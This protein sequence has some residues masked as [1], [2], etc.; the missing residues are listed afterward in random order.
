MY[1]VPYISWVLKHAIEHKTKCLYFISRDGYQLK[2]IA[3][4]IIEKKNLPIRTKYIYGS[5]R[6]WRI[7]SLITEL[8]KEFFSKFG[9]FVNVKSYDKMLN[10]LNM[11]S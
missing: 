8:D 5:R 3:D 1:F 11:E 10:A 4:R 9:N 7:P 6:A 2:R